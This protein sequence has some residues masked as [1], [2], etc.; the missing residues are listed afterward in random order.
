MK[1]NSQNREKRERREKRESNMSEQMMK[2]DR[3]PLLSNRRIKG[4]KKQEGL[5]L[6]GVL[7]A[8]VVG[9]IATVIVIAYYGNVE[10]SRKASEMQ[11]A[12]ATMS[13]NI[14]SMAQ[15]TDGSY[16][17]LTAQTVINS[18]DV[19]SSL[20]KGAAGAQVIGTSWY[21]GNH[22]STID[23][24][25]ANGNTQFTVTL[26]QIPKEACSKIGRYFLGKNSQGVSGNGQ[27]AATG[28][29]L[30]TACA[31]N[32]PASLAITFN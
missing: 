13:S 4:F 5:S 17:G 32:D 24:A 20:I 12:I 6:I 28:P 27:A 30:A 31:Q 11:Q 15:A 22:N 8:I 7:L 23:V 9:A 25:P 10:E 3:Q 14:N 16:L 21:A 29:D 19:V 1:N 18:G 26:N 2:A